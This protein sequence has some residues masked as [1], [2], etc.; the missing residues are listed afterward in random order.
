MAEPINGH[1]QSGVRCP[2]C[3][4]RTEIRCTRPTLDGKVVRYRY[5]K[6]CPY[7]VKTEEQP[8]Q[9]AKK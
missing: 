1:D 9:V 6:H 8:V 7:R 4:S 2:R 3:R 5:C